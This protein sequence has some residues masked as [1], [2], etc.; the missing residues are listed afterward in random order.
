M[1]YEDLDTYNEDTMHDMYVD[2]DY[3]INT[4]ELPEVFDEADLNEHIDNLNDWD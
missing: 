1:N 3:E 2:S 4:G